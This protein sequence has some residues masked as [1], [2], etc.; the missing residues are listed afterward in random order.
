M[1]TEKRYITTCFRGQGQ[2]PDS[3][4]EN[5][6]ILRGSFIQSFMR[7]VVPEFRDQSTSQ[8]VSG[9]RLLYDRDY[10]YLF[11]NMLRFTLHTSTVLTFLLCLDWTNF[12]AP[13]KLCI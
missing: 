9:F 7:S 5:H 6:F 3:L 1:N 8:S 4:C 12:L 13:K 11:L 2:E 10:N